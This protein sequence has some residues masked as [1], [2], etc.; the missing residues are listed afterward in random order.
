MNS[1]THS[2]EFIIVS[3]FCIL[4]Y[5]VSMMWHIWLTSASLTQYQ[6][7]LT[8]RMRWHLLWCSFM[9]L[10]HPRCSYLICSTRA[11]VCPSHLYSDLACSTMF[12]TVLQCVTIYNH[13]PS[14]EYA[15]AVTVERISSWDWIM[16]IPCAPMHMS[17]LTLSQYF[18]WVSLGTWVVL[19]DIVYFSSKIRCP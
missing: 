19:L 4:L 7:I 13:F 14:V 9:A 2:C 11:M 3:L 18:S 16:R 12:L 15:P 17:N 6:R 5:F 8:Q 1:V 10:E